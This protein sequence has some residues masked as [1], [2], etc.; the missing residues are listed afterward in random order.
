MIDLLFPKRCPLCQTVMNFG[1]SG[2]CEEC[3]K[4]LCWVKDPVCLKCG[5]T[6]QDSEMEYCTDCMKIQ[7]SF[8]RCYPAF[9]YEGKIKDSLYEFKYKNQR[10]FADFYCDCIIKRHGK[11]LKNL[12]L[13]GV[14]P[15]PVHT[16]KKKYRGYNQAQLIANKISKALKVPLYSDYLV[17][18]T[19]TNPQKELDDRQR[20]KNLKNA[21]KIAENV[22]KLDTVLLVDDIYTSGATMEA[23]T[24]AL[25]D[26]GVGKV[27]C[28][29]VA[30]GRGY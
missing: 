19:D 25:K 9:D 3:E 27:Y 11:E 17:R 15:V 12:S 6:I 2:V 8:E 1:I 7:K 24:I 28:A 30:I 14:I 18:I 26:V 29:S 13:D 5:K 16:R 20:M 23:C 21:F 22:V 4:N 10:Q